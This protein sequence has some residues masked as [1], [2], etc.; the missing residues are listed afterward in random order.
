MDINKPHAVNRLH[1]LHAFHA[2][3]SSSNQTWIPSCQ[4]PHAPPKFLAQCSSFIS[5]PTPQRR[6]FV[7]KMIPPSWTACMSNLYCKLVCP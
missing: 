2:T 6:L 5:S 4:Q 3:P 1:R 7:C